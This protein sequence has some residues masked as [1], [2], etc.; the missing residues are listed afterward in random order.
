MEESIVDE[1]QDV[2]HRRDWVSNAKG[3]CEGYWSYQSINAKSQKVKEEIEYPYQTAMEDF[4]GEI[5]EQL[6]T[7]D[8]WMVDSLANLFEETFNRKELSRVEAAELIVNFVQDI[9]YTFVSTEIC[10]DYELREYRG[11]CIGEQ[12]FGI[13]APSEFMHTLK[14]DCDTRSVLLYALL[15]KFDYLPIIVVSREYA[16]AM[17]AIDL[18][19]TGDHIRYQGIE[20]YFWET[21]AT[22]WSV[23][24]LPP[25][26]N[27]L[28]YW[29]VALPPFTLKTSELL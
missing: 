24:M 25:S 6:V 23:G 28:D 29:K 12:K 4:W 16:H 15:K 14:G 7:R 13:L 27:V 20:Y 3:Y 26:M 5:Y 8:Q 9:E 17:I 11:R 10:T 1:D 21:T 18:P 19:V 22:G 2:Y